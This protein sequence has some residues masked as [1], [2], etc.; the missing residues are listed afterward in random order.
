MRR[1]VAVDG[2]PGSENFRV[3]FGD[4]IVRVRSADADSRPRLTSA[5]KAMS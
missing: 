4:G 1:R 3:T 2:K 5:C